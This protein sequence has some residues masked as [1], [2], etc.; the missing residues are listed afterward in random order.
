VI[1]L[2]F[3]ISRYR[4]LADFSFITR[5]FLIGSAFFVIAASIFGLS[6]FALQSIRVYLIPINM[7]VFL[8]VI[9]VCMGGLSQP[10]YR[11]TRSL[12]DRTFFPEYYERKEKLERLGQE[13]LLTK[14]SMEFH[15]TILDSIVSSFKII[16]TCL[17]VWNEQ[18]GKFELQ[19]ETGWDVQNSEMKKRL[20]LGNPIIKYLK[21]N[22]YLLLDR[23]RRDFSSH[24]DQRAL[25][26]SM[27]ELD[28]TLC[29]PLRT[30]KNLFGVF[31]FSD[32]ESG[33]SYGSDDI[34]MLKDLAD[35]VTMA[36][37]KFDI[38]KRWSD[39]LNQNQLMSQ[40][41]HR[42][43][44]PSIA[45][46]VLKRVDQREGWKGER[47]Y[48]SIL[49]SDLRGF[50]SISENHAPEDV[51][52]CLNEYFSEMI[53]I[54]VSNGGTVD[55]FMGDAVLVV[56]GAPL[57]V[58]DVEARATV[59]AIEMQ[60]C[61]K[62][63]NKR[64][65]DRGLFSLEMGIGIS[66]GEVVAGNVGSD[67]RMDY[68]VIGDTVNVSSR[69]QSLAGSG[70]ILVTSNI[71]ERVKERVNF[72]KMYPIPVRGRKQPIEISEILGLKDQS[73]IE[74]Q[75]PNEINLPIWQKQKGA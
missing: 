24:V 69:L 4:L 70:Q 29:I 25:A 30:G 44:S 41:L 55:K 43:M 7:T 48:V 6:F 54:I 61:L 3:A 28:A 51:V 36:L 38:T 37:E 57:P 73:V 50:T 71:M 19:S 2:S 45:D 63:I 65:K 47:R 74:G 17:F 16:K 72:I 42:Y 75:N 68:T 56:F 35:H 8:V 11:K 40:I 58:K 34:K 5:R 46:E 49:V 12:I 10:L 18:E 53:E 21:E 67:K 39:E 31:V 59:C 1:I 52:Q 23:I 62:N 64:R 14:S 33:L 60:S 15:R 32:K 9:S 13:I 26:R 27:L 22:E 66:A 20:Q